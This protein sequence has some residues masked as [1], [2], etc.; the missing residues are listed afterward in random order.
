M[1][2]SVD[3][4]E[5]FELTETQKKVICNDIPTEIIDEDLK[6][7]LHYI[8]DHKY[9]QC[10][11]RLKDSWMEKLEENGITSIPLND[12]AFAN[13]VFAQPNYKNR[14]KRNL[15]EERALNGNQ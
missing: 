13:L 15:E 9:K 12:D 8:L 6:R 1:K 7:R 11:K 4:Q 14:S 5:L 10:M 2:I 3:G